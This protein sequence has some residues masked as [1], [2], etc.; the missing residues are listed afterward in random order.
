MPFHINQHTTRRKNP[1]AILA[2]YAIL[3][4]GLACGFPIGGDPTPRQ[5]ENLPSPTLPPPPPTATPNPL[6]PGLVESDPPARAEVASK[7]PIT[8]FFNQPMDRAS[9]EFALASQMQQ[10]LTFTW[11]DDTTVIVY[12]NEELSP[13]F[14]AG[15]GAWRQCSLS[16][17]PST[18]AADQLEL[19]HSRV[20]G[21]CAGPPGAQ[22]K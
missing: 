5:P 6:P 8:L 16:P 22:L 19:P 15:T 13:D 11:V 7:G 21:D 18:H 9:V 3:I 10:E 1:T 17:G 14:K 4:V 20:S 12:F 2:I